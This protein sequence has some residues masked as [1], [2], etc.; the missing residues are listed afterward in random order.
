MYVEQLD[1]EYSIRVSDNSSVFTT[2]LLAI[3]WA[4][5]FVEQA[6][7]EEV[8]ICSDSAAALQALKAGKS[9]ARQDIVMDILSVM[10][11]ERECSD[12]LL[13]PR[14]C[15]GKREREGGSPGQGKLKQGNG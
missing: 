1:L 13:G 15:R 10:N 11:R 14:T 2:E 4:V 5:K 9:N 12:L 7:P 3:F 6:K 8:V